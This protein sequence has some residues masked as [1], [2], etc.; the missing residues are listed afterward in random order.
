MNYEAD[1]EQFVRIASTHL[2]S[3]AYFVGTEEGAGYDGMTHFDMWLDE[4]SWAETVSEFPVLSKIWEEFYS[5]KFERSRIIKAL[6]D[7]M[8]RYGRPV[9]PLGQVAQVDILD[10]EIVGEHELVRVEDLESMD[11]YSLLELLRL[12]AIIRVDDEE[13]LQPELILSLAPDKIRFVDY[14]IELLRGDYLEE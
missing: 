3:L 8:V 5:L 9:F 13:Y 6:T 1:L 10:V 12:N 2:T 7:Y 4:T 14:S 11:D